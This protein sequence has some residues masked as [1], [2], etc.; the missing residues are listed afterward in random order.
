MCGEK[1]AD[2]AGDPTADRHAL[3]QV[4]SL[5]LV[6]HCLCA[7]TRLEVPEQLS[8]G[9]LKVA[10]LAA[11]VDANQDALWRVLRLLADHRIVTFEGDRVGLT[12]RDL[13]ESTGWRLERVVASPGPMSVIQAR[14]PEPGSR[15]G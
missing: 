1:G 5:G 9:P 11:A 12:D 6:W 4:I 10:E 2:M 7:I 14:R 15:L 8:A 13:L 3:A